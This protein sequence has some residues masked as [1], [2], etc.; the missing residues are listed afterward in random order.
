MM[1]IMVM[2]TLTLLD[3]QCFF[4][5]E[6]SYLLTYL[7]TSSFEDKSSSTHSLDINT[8]VIFTLEYNA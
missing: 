6:L 8:T 5:D 3:W 1:G 2:I 4:D 7:L